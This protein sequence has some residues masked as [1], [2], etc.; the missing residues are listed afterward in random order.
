[1][2]RPDTNQAVWPQIARGLERRGIV[3]TKVQI[4]CAV[5][6][7]L[8]CTFVFAYAKCWF[9]HDMAHICLPC[10]TDSDHNC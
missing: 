7:Q 8:I 9:S 10:Q 1:M 3:Q 6:M 2:T 5:I 4:S